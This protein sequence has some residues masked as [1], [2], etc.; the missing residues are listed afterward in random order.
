MKGVQAEGWFEKTE[1]NQAM[2]FGSLPDWAKELADALPTNLFSS[3]VAISYI[4]ILL[5]SMSLL[6]IFQF[7]SA[8]CTCACMRT[9][10]IPLMF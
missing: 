2:C 9:A 10:T 6:Q 7:F 1:M 5:M 4:N 8:N 3:K